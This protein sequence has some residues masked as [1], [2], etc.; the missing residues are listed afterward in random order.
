MTAKGHMA[1]ATTFALASIDIAT[2]YF[3]DIDYQYL[4]IFYIGVLFGSVLPDIDEDGS[5]IGR[6]LSFISIII[7]SLL[8]HRTFTHYLILPIFILSSILLVDKL[9]Q[10]ALII[11]ISFGVLAHDM[12]DMLTKGGINGFF[13]PFFPN[14]KI[15]LL[16]KSLRFYT[17]SDTENL[18]ILILTIT[19]G[20][21][22]YM[23]IIYL[24]VVYG[25]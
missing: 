20:F 14:R 21:L 5:Y 22:F 7:S 25:F 10:E 2:K 16:P 8:K 15:A 1:L 17:G 4:I 9:W 3:I 18:F 19:N 13:F 6:K 11:G 24:R 12:G 23:L